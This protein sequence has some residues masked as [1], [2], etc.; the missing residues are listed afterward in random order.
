MKHS[1]AKRKKELKKEISFAN[2]S[3]WFW[4]I[5]QRCSLWSNDEGCDEERHVNARGKEEQ[6]RQEL[7]FLPLKSIMNRCR[8]ISWRLWFA[9]EVEA[10]PVTSEAGGVW[11][12]WKQVGKSWNQSSVV[13]ISQV[14]LGVIYL[15]FIFHFLKITKQ[16]KWELFVWIY[17]PGPLWNKVAALILPL[18]HYS[19]SF[20][21]SAAH[22]WIVMLH[23]RELKRLREALLFLETQLQMTFFYFVHR[24]SSFHI[25]CWKR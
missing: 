19:T 17:Q 21:N 4:V 18:W 6:I 11:R 10:T 22:L 7:L 15:F 24:G 1:A 9:W 12:L 13:I 16:N 25:I 20:V 23:H 3:Q 8:P 14:F 2:L 5:K